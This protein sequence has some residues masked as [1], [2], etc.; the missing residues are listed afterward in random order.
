MLLKILNIIYKNI[1]SS[2]KVFYLCD[3]TVIK[4]IIFTISFL[5]L[6]YKKNAF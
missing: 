5:V 4:K 3:M 1:Y 6:I 2:Q